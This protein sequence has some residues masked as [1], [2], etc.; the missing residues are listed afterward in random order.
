LASGIRYRDEALVHT[1]RFYDEKN[2][3]S[4]EGK[5][6]II[7]VELAKAEKLV[8]E[9]AAEE[10]DAAEAWAAFFRYHTEKE[11]RVLVNE[12]LKQR[13]D[14]AMAGENILAFSQEEIEWFHNESKLKYKLDMQDMQARYL[15]EGREEGFGKGKE[16]GIAEGLGR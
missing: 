1:F 14:I 13:E 8:R 12:L 5:T 6:H 2:F 15:R 11:K 3:L 7:T 9:K 4:F 16:E 10:M